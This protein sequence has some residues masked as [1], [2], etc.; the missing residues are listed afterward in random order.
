MI[1]PTLP[2]SMCHMDCIAP[3]EPASSKQHRCA[4]CVIDDCMRWPSVFLLRNVTVKVVCDSLI[5]LFMI[6]GLPEV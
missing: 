6:V 3:I 5:E 2:F 1:R 4:L